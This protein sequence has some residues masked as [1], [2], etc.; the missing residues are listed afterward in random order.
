MANYIMAI[1]FLISL[2]VYAQSP[3]PTIEMDPPVGPQGRPY[4][5]V[6]NAQKMLLCNDRDVIEAYLKD[7]Y[8]QT[9]I[10]FG[11]IA[12]QMDFPGMVISIY[13]NKLT[14]D[15]SV[16]EHSAAGVSCIVTGGQQLYLDQEEGL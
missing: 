15:F 4:G 9:S 5:Q 8:G 13:K 2:E 7:S 12:N 6:F 10:G 11:Y 3:E 1:L 16:V 14:N